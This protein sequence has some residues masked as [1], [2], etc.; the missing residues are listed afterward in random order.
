MTGGAGYIGSQTV[1][2]LVR[3]G[4]EPVVIDTL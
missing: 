2:L 3:R 4:H 1:R